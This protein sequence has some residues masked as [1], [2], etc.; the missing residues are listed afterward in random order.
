M[1]SSRHWEPSGPNGPTTNW[2]TGTTS[3]EWERNLCE[4]KAVA[5]LERMQAG[6]P[7]LIKKDE[8]EML[9]AIVL[10]RPLAEAKASVEALN[11]FTQGHHGDHARQTE[12][13][14]HCAND[15]PRGKR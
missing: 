3:E 2:I 1:H 15:Q 14:S 5:I 6:R 7:A 8:G 9:I 13:S 12:P 10:D 11:A 4:N